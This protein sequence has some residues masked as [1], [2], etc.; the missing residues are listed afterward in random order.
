MECPPQIKGR[1][2][3]FIGRKAM[4]ID[5][6]G[7]ETVDVLVEKNLIHSYADLYELNFDQIVDLERMGDK[8][9]DNLLKGLELS[10]TVPFERVLFSLGI[11][12]VGETVAKKLAKGL[13]SIDAIQ[14]ATFDQLISIDEIGEK[15]AISVQ[16]FFLDERN[17]QIIEKLKN[18]GLQFEIKE[19]EGLTNLF[20]GKIF[21][22]SG[23]FSTFSRDELKEVIEMNGGKNAS[24]ISSK[25]TYVIAGENMGPSKL[26]KATDLGVE[27]LSEDQFIQL[28]KNKF[29]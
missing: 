10:K 18:V 16:Q 29:G 9:A 25:T 22:V 24:S 17:I 23:V 1:I 12:F 6:L 4:N 5:G 8:S 11:R 13:K 21:V 3:H 20:E 27:I 14:K 19:K 7:A 26:K 2:E 28:L 15:I